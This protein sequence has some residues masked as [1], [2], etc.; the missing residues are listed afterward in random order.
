[1]RLEALLDANPKIGRG[2]GLHH[3]VTPAQ[4]KQ[5]LGPGGALETLL[6]ARQEGKVKALGFSA[7]TTKGALAALK[8]FRFDTVMFPINFV[9]FFERG[10]GQAVLDLAK[11]QGAAVLAI[12]PLSRG[13]WPKGLSVNNS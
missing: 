9:E 6:E 2:T 11:A 12:K 7:H 8:G 4:V 13:A 1:M 5:A 3:I 10:T